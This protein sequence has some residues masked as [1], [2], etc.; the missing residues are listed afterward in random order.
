MIIQNFIRRV[1][2]YFSSLLYTKELKKSGQK[3]FFDQIIAIVSNCNT[4]SKSSLEELKLDDSAHA[5]HMIQQVQHSF[6]ALIHQRKVLPN[7]KGNIKILPKSLITFA[8]SWLQSREAF[9]LTINAIENH[10]SYIFYRINCFCRLIIWQ[11]SQ[12][13][14]RFLFRFFRSNLSSLQ[15]LNSLLKHVEIHLPS[16]EATY[17][18]PETIISTPNKI[19]VFKKLSNFFMLI[20]RTIS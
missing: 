11:L 5:P 18:R 2:Q 16:V 12:L 8:R 3:A 14:L 15:C 13:L 4:K 17:K 20:N 6:E 9:P 7:F 10:F 19:S 1:K